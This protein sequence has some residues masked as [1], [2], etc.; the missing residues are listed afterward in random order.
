MSIRRLVE[1]L[2][3]LQEPP[4]SLNQIR[5]WIIDNHYQDEIWFI[6]TSKFAKLGGAVR[7]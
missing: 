5:Q 1:Y 7:F 4:V 6:P 2:S 3:T